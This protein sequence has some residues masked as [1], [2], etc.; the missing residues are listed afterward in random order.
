M[1]PPMTT[2][3]AFHPWKRSIMFK[4]SSND[5]PQTVVGYRIKLLC[6]SIRDRIVP[7]NA[8]GSPAFCTTWVGQKWINM[9]SWWNNIR[10]G[11]ACQGGTLG[12][13][14]C[15]LRGNRNNVKRNT[16]SLRPG[17]D[18]IFRIPSEVHGGSAVAVGTVLRLFSWNDRL[19]GFR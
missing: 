18:A 2:P 11:F 10:D 17:M 9:S 14:I 4:K 12:S 19:S 13:V 3:G 15:F 1:K 6:I 16:V 8:M 7:R 5:L